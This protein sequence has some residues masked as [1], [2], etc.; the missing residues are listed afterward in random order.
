[1]LDEGR[2]EQ[3]NGKLTPRE[4]VAVEVVECGGHGGLGTHDLPLCLDAAAWDSFCAA[5]QWALEPSESSGP[6]EPGKPGKPRS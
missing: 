1:M 5:L 3:A 6:T 4:W 2:G